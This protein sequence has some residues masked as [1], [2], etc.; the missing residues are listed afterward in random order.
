MLTI[1]SSNAFIFPV[2]YFFYPETS[3]RSLEEMD[4]IF[5]KTTNVFNVVSVARNEP[6]RYGKHGELLINYEDTEQHLRRASHVS[7][8]RR[9]GFTAGSELEGGKGAHIEHPHT[10]MSDTSS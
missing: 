4:T 3:Y 1:S 8:K 7:E 2:V 5:N 9:S 10:S 6:H